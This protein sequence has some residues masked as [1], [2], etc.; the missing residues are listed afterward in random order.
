MY[1]NSSSGYGIYWVLQDGDISIEPIISLLVK[2]T[3]LDVGHLYLM[4][5]HLH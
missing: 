4:F 3:F 5:I 2:Q 1:S